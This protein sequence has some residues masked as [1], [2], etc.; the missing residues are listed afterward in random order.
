MFRSSRPLATVRDASQLFRR[1][2]SEKEGLGRVQGRVQRVDVAEEQFEDGKTD[3][4]ELRREQSEKETAN[5]RVAFRLNSGD[6]SL[7]AS[8]GQLVALL[9][10]VRY[11]GSVSDG[12]LRWVELK[13]VLYRS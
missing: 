6:Q 1:D 13:R 3:Y 10:G 12:R 9:G 4:R 7:E 8:P 11:G 5:G 2:L